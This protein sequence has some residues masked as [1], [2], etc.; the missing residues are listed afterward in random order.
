MSLGGLMAFGDTHGYG[1]RYL[2]LCGG[3][4]LRCLAVL[5]VET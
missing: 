1:R 4:A 2:S 5:L 3:P